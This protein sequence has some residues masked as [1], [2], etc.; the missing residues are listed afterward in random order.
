MGIIAVMSTLAQT[1]KDSKRN[2]HLSSA[3]LG[4]QLFLG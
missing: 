1:G 4:Q 3:T 2:T